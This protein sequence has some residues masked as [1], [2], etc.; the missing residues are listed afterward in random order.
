MNLL[1]NQAC[2]IMYFAIIIVRRDAKI[3][4]FVL[5]KTMR[6]MCQNGWIILFSSKI[7]TDMYLPGVRNVVVVVDS[8]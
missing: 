6:T 2:H 4:C 7:V 8:S 1:V 3:F 5:M